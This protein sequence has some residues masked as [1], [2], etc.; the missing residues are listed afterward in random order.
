LAGTSREALKDLT[1]WDGRV[2]AVALTPDGRWVVAGLSNGTCH[3]SDLTGLHG[4]REF[5]LPGGTIAFIVLAPDGHWVLVGTKDGNCRVWDFSAGLDGLRFLDAGS[6][7]ALM[8][9]AKRD[10]P[11]YG[12]Q[13][14]NTTSELWEQTIDAETYS[15]VLRSYGH[16]GRFEALAVTP[17]G[18]RAVSSSL[19]GTCR[20]WDL[21]TGVCTRVLWGHT[22]T[23]KSVAITPD[24][25][26]SISGASD[27]TCR[28]WDLAAGVCTRVLEGHTG[29]VTAVAVTPD[30]RRAISASEDGTCRTWNLAL[31]E[32]IAAFDPD[33]K[34]TGVAASAEGIFMVG[35]T[36]GAV[37][38][39]RLHV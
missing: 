29:G 9:A 39:L 21:A 5:Q 4:P 35:D 31:G 20:V 3:V 14:W 25:R 34:P 33:G 8:A 23:I 28:V 16:F 12:A 10:S 32:E 27:K 37:H 19:H 38:F 22:G 11:W 17:D 15:Q 18:R 36:G 13:A 1:R 30:G 7:W 6:R 24:G 26:W 2:D